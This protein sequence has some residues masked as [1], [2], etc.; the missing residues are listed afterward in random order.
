VRYLYPHPTAELGR[1]EW[2]EK[3][4]SMALMMDNEAWRAD[5]P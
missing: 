1:V 5:L 4:N 2:D 3:N